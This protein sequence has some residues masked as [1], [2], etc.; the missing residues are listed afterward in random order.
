MARIF[1]YIAASLDGF[2]AAEDG[3]LDWL[4]KYDTMDLGEHDY[5]LFLKRMRTIVMGRGTYDFI[6][7]SPDP[8]AYG[9]QRV[10]V[11]TSG[12]ID[13]PKGPLETRHDVD[14]LIG[15]LRALDDGDVWMLG[16][17]RLQM[18][19]MERGALDEIEIYVIPELIGGGPVLFPP[20]GFKASPRLIDARA[21]DRGCVRLHYAFDRSVA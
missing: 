10:I 16:G 5:R 17:G 2:I 13:N 3:S 6:A 1:G 15:E 9:D 21:I 7:G 4:F 20:T 14:A 18:A 12:P 19:F 11:V 8:W